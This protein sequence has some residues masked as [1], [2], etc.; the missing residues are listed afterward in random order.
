MSSIP[1]TSKTP[2]DYP[3]SLTIDY[4]DR[5][6][7][8]L[9][10]F[11]RIFAAIPICIITIFLSGGI[12]GSS[13]H[14]E[15]WHA[16][17]ATGGIVVLPL[18]LM[19]LFREKYPRWW[20]DWNLA[21]TRFTYRVASYVLLLR[22]EYPSTDEE[23][24]IHLEL[25]YPDVKTQLGR[26]WPLVKWLLAIPHYVVLI[27][28]VIAAFFVWIIA[29]FAILFTGR[30]PRGLFNFMV[31]VLRWGLRVSAYAYLLITD[32]YPVF[33]LDA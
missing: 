4:P 1:A 5:N 15:A 21:L 9:T 14:N 3:A 30:Y 23:Q 13:S 29:W 2:A 22:D 17:I 16:G 25:A 18:V 26:G 11:F 31:S 7:N 33:S 8:R 6:L 12:Q 19:I 28:L 27:F 32:K 24:A 20:F 10:S